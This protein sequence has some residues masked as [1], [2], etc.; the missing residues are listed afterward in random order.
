[1]DNDY[2]SIHAPPRGA[3]CG[4]PSSR[5]AGRI[6]IHAP[7]R[8][9]TAVFVVERDAP[10]F[11]FTPLREG[12]PK[13]SST[14]SRCSD[15]NS[16]PSAR[17][18]NH[19]GQGQPGLL[20][21]NSRPSARG[22]DGR[23]VARLGGQTISIHAPPRGATVLV[24]IKTS[25]VVYFNSR[26]SARGDRHNLCE[27]DDKLIISIHAPP[28]GATPAAR[29][30]RRSMYFNSRPSARGDVIIPHWCILLIFISIHAPPRG[31]TSPRG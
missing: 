15:F 17:G 10:L 21:F 8:G 23:N 11:Q 18:D 9:A 4:A 24:V 28:R 30:T 25:T 20:H 19:P 29:R 3:T 12:R 27:Y 22:D 1:M 6:S 7:P 31:A 5:S 2:I 16:R 26:P 13:E 14:T